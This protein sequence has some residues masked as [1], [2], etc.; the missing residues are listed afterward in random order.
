MKIKFVLIMLAAGSLVSCSYNAPY[1]PVTGPE[2]I[3]FRNDRLDVYPE[4]VRKDPARYASLSMAWAALIVTN[5]ATEEA[6][7]GKIRMDTV[8]EHRYFDWEQDEHGA[9]VRLL[10]SPRGEGLFRMRWSMNR[11]DMTASALDAM[12]YAAAG[13]LALVYATPVSVD[14]DGTIVMRYHYIRVLGPEHFTA[15][16]LDYGRI[17]EPFRPIDARPRPATNSPSR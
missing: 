6:N 11:Q 14:D 5:N 2:K 8:F 15:N 3:E 7:G 4:D 1:R 17:G 13:K 9:C 10:I 16:E 12:N